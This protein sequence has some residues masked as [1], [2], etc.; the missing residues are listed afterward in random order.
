MNQF[1]PEVALRDNRNTPE[2]V[3]ISRV[4]LIEFAVND[5]VR[6]LDLTVANL[7]MSPEVAAHATREAEIANESRRV[8]LDAER[9]LTDASVAGAQRVAAAEAG[10]I[11]PEL[12]RQ[13]VEAAQR[14]NPLF[15]EII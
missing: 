13:Q 11:D 3:G 12:A 14:Q 6:A 1:Q 10:M 2:H 4:N 7:P 8:I 5:T 15:E 9:I